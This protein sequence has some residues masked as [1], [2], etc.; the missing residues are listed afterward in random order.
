MSGPFTI[1][2]WNGTTERIVIDCSHKA[3]SVAITAEDLKPTLRKTKFPLSLNIIFIKTRPRPAA[4]AGY[5]YLH[6]K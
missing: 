3:D 4:P 2:R 1:F 5:R 6:M